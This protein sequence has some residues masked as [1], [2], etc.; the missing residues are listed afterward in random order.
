M[1]M[2]TTF[3]VLFLSICFWLARN[4][5]LFGIFRRAK[6]GKKNLAYP[7]HG[8]NKPNFFLPHNYKNIR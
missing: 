5:K 3:G 2:V 1:A 6:S 4:K 7:A 8:K